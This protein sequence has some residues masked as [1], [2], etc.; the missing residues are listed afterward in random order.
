MTKA[1]VRQQGDINLHPEFEDSG[2]FSI[3]AIKRAIQDIQK[4]PSNKFNTA[5]IDALNK[6][7]N[8]LNDI[9]KQQNKPLETD[10]VVTA[11]S[12]D[13]NIFSEEGIT[14]ETADTEKEVNDII[15]TSDPKEFKSPNGAGLVAYLSREW[16]VKN[17]SK[18]SASNSAILNDA[19]KLILDPNR[20]R[21]DEL[22][23]FVINDSPNIPVYYNGTKSTWGAVKDEIENSNLSPEDKTKRIASLVP[24][25]IETVQGPLGFVHDINWINSKN[26]VEENLAA[27]RD[28]LMSLREAIYNGTITT[29][30]ITNISNGHLIRTVNNQYISTLEAFPDDKLK[31]AIY[32]NGDFTTKVD[33]LLNKPENLKEGYTYALLPARDGSTM[34]VPL[35]RNLL[36]SKQVSS[37]SQAIRIFIKAKKGE[38]LNTGEQQVVDK[39]K[40]IIKLKNSAGNNVNFDIR[41]TDG[42][43]NYVSIFTY[44][45]KADKMNLVNTIVSN[46]S[47]YRAISIEE[48]ANSLVLSLA[49]GAGINIAT[50]KLDHQTGNFL[51]EQEFLDN[52]EDHLQGCYF[53]G[54]S[55]LINKDK[56][57]IPIIGENNLVS[58]ES[59]SYTTYV[60]R[61]TSSNV[62][63]WNLGTEENPNYVYF[64]QP[65]VSFDTQTAKAK[66]QAARSNVPVKKEIIENTPVSK[67]EGDIDLDA[68]ETNL[69]DDDLVYNAEAFL[70]EEAYKDFGTTQEGITLITSNVKIIKVPMQRQ[71]INMIS[72]KIARALIGSEEATLSSEKIKSILSE[73]KNWFER[74]LQLAKQANKTKVVEHLQEYLD[75]WSNLERLVKN[76][77]AKRSG[78]K[79]SEVQNSEIDSLAE[80]GEDNSEH[81]RNYFSDT[82]SLELDSK[83]TVSAKMKLFLSFIPNGK[84]NYL[85]QESQFEPFDI[86]YNSLSAMLAGTKPSYTAMINKLTEINQDG[87]VFPWLT[88]LLAKLENAPDQI[89]REFVTA[90]NKHY[91]S[92]K[93]AMWRKVNKDNYAMEVWDA[94]ANSIQQTIT[95]AWYNNLINSDLT[96]VREGEYIYDPEVTRQI[97]LQYDEWVKKKH[98]PTQSELDTWLKRLGIVLSP[99]SLETLTDGEFTYGG[100]KYTYPQL[101]QGNNSLFGTLVSKLQ[102]DGGIGEL[103]NVLF[104]DSIAKALIN[105]EARNTAHIFSNSHRSGSKTVYSYTNDKYIIDRYTNLMSDPILLTRLSKLS[106]NSKASWLQQLLKTND[107]GEYVYNEDGLA[108]INT[109]SLF[110]KNFAYDYLALDSIKELGTKTYRETRNLNTLSPAEHE[111]VKMT[112]F[113]NNGSVTKDGTRIGKMF[114]PT[115]SDKTTMILLTVPLVNISLNEDGE[116]SSDTVDFIYDNLVQAEIDRILKWQTITNNGESP[117]NVASYNDGAKLFMLFPQLNEIEELYTYIGDKRVLKDINSSPELINIIKDTLQSLLDNKVDQQVAVWNKLGV[118]LSDDSFNFIDNKYLGYIRKQIASKDKSYIQRFAAADFAINYIIS[119]ANVSHRRPCFIL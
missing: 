61:H 103:G 5:R 57:D 55:T 108:E 87:K 80:F 69:N 23:H 83:D 53:Y 30:R 16:L 54:N 29:S 35:K 68:L 71:V 2:Y 85:T 43:K 73:N 86:V 64:N 101:F 93:F 48:N 9:F 107:L 111:I 47:D 95:N 60:K 22:I 1:D 76:T 89:K 115:M 34:A 118:G 17:G 100:R 99:K 26:V 74:Q 119:N 59:S 63:S 27:D 52:L 32:K 110:F 45:H 13:S 12:S 37:I 11:S 18:V 46:P 105:L 31:F 88:N 40:E 19:T 114:Y 4:R 39:I 92:M 3:G 62:L 67:H 90:M 94:N 79:V 7:I 14:I 102:P 106:F 24:I 38:K 58:I 33:K 65:S 10:K 70:D 42:I 44:V 6:L 81:E 25:A 75:N 84:T 66:A 15:N 72:E 56:V 8:R 28:N 49:R 96:T 91:V 36:T 116:V 104:S 82:Y 41:T 21:G 51:K 117:I 20:L 109:E 98:Y 113:T 77:L 50:A 112:M 97:T 78:F